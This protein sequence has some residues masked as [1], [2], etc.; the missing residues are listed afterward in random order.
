[1]SLR[2]L[3]VLAPLFLATACD[4]Q[5]DAPAQPANPAPAPQAAPAPGPDG[6]PRVPGEEAAYIDRSHAGQPAAK[7]R[8]TGP[9]GPRTIGDFKG[10]VL[11]NL[12]ATWCGPCVRE[13]PSLDRLAAREAG[14][15]TV[16]TINQD[17]PQADDVVQP[18]WDKASLKT[19]ALYREPKTDFSFEYGGG[20][21]PTTILFR[22]GRE[23]WRVHG[24]MEWDGAPAWTL[25]GEGA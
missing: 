11:V 20:M 23:V 7:I 16:L 6:L 9:D 5:K 12:W 17:L 21:L 24:G 10:A 15:L 22:D 14:R 19:L 3:I 25:L 2:S 4:R 8:F 1:M 13:M 18:W